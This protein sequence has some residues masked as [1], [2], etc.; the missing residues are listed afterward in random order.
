MQS[1]APYL[2]TSTSTDMLLA[3]QRL[4]A[5][6][7]SYGV[8]DC[9]SNGYNLF[10]W[11]LQTAEIGKNRKRSLSRTWDNN[12]V[13]FSATPKNRSIP[14]VSVVVARLGKIA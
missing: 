4:Y 12:Q 3:V 11:R 2:K 10:R 8:T 1:A 9:V 13:S 5:L 7:D 14:R 6:N